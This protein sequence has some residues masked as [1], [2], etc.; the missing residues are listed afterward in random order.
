MGLAQDEKVIQALAAKGAYDPLDKRVLPGR[1]RG[2]ADL[3][4]PHPLDSPPELLAVDRVSITKQESRSRIV[5]ERLDDLLSG[6]DCRGVVRD[7]DVEEFAALVAEHHEENRRRKVRVGT[8][9]KSTA[10]MS[11]ACAPPPIS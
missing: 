6:P 10:T 1:A 7:I 2:D 11:R 3:V 4:D 9:K 5:R 8:R